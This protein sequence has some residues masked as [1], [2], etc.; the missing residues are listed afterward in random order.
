MSIAG[1]GVVPGELGV[2]EPARVRRFIDAARRARRDWF[3]WG[4]GTGV[5]AGAAVV[6]VV[7]L[8]VFAGVFAP[9]VPTRNSHAN[10]KAETVVKP[11]IPKP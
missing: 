9:S 11:K 4:V 3:G 10:T 7:V 1:V 2:P 8:L 6:V 5:G